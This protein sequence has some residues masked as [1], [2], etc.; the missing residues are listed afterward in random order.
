MY[1]HGPMRALV[2]VVTDANREIQAMTFAIKSL[3]TVA[4]ETCNCPECYRARNLRGSAPVISNAPTG[5]VVTFVSIR[6]VKA[7]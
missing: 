6:S 3:A 5:P 4:A 2:P 1:T 7:A